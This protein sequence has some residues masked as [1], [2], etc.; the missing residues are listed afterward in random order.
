MIQCSAQALP[1]MLDCIVVQAQTGGQ[2]LF[3]VQVRHVP[4]LPGCHHASVTN[5]LIN[6]RC[7]GSEA[8]GPMFSLCVHYPVQT[9]MLQQAYLLSEVILSVN[10]QV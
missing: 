3:D 2:F 1:M 4:Q 9:M 5:K 8:L 10:G 6:H 7:F